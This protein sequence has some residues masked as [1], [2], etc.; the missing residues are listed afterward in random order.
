VF[1]VEDNINN[2]LKNKQ[3]IISFIQ[4]LPLLST[5]SISIILIFI[6]VKGIKTHFIDDEQRTSQIIISHDIAKSKAKVYYISSIL[7]DIYALN[8]DF[9]TKELKTTIDRAYKLID[10]FY[11]Q[12]H[13]Q[14]SKKIL[15]DRIKILLED[16]EFFIDKDKHLYLY[17]ISNK[18]KFN[19]TTFKCIKDIKS[20]K[21]VYKECI[22]FNKI[23]NKIDKIKYYVRY[24]KP[25]DITL[26]SE[27]DY[28]KIKKDIESKLVKF[29]P[30]LNHDNYLIIINTQGKILFGNSIENLDKVI[31][32]AIEKKIGVVKFNNDVLVYSYNPNLD[33]VI[34]NKIDLTKLQESIFKQNEEINKIISSVIG[35]FLGVAIVFIIII[36]I[37]TF[38]I[39]HIIKQ[40][41]EKYEFALIS[42]KEKAQQAA[43][44][45]SEFLAN[46]SHEI[47][48]PLNAMFGFI[49]ILQEKDLDKESKKYLTIIERSGE[50]LLTII[51]DILDFS[52]IESG[53]FD[54]EKIEFNPK[55]EIL[56]LKELFSS[57]ASEKHI[58]L[59]FQKMNLKYNII[60]DPTRLKQVIANLLSNAIKFTPSDKKV[61]LNVEYDENKEELFVEVID[62]GIGIE[63]YK[64]DS[65]FEAFSQADTS[66][67]RKYGGTGLGLT[68]SYKLV[69]LLGGELKVESEVNKG[70]RF[71]FTIPA[72]KGALAKEVQPIKQYTKDDEKFDF[73][74]LLVEDNK[75]NQMFMKIILDKVGIKYDIANDGIEAVE[76]FQ[77][78]R[79]DI[80]LM[81]ENMP[82]MNGIEATKEIRGIEKYLNLKPVVIVALTANALVGDEQRFILAGMDY[83]V[84]KPI[85]IDKLKEILLKIK[86]D[87]K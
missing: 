27:F 55:E 24:F 45:K 32:L 10:N 39:T 62:E 82:R 3:K 2:I 49:K 19:K 22:Y 25:L 8:K 28:Y 69:K 21:G 4:F 86:K 47:R 17:S 68:I 36:L 74:V 12:H 67:T 1:K 83:Y 13:T 46:M 42:E 81:D 6:F 18:I 20:S 80:I 71:Y 15:V 41:F 43:Q 52:K 31:K 72:K 64:L 37:I 57:I 66:T 61:I 44:A 9:C 14:T 35:Q 60:S 48:T 50:N 40:I 84:P 59:E 16:M 51:N 29:V 63:K 73:N 79:Y 56:I 78:N 11:H 70:S 85:D 75:A 7:T 65:I 5:I 53:K 33:F 34:I 26:V 30:S 76:K 77:Q 38:Y 58:L 54:I 87:K 23:T